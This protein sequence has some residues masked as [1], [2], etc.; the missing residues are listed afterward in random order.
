MHQGSLNI[1]CE[2]H[3]KGFQH[4]KFRFLYQ[5]THKSNDHCWNYKHQLIDKQHTHSI[6]WWK[7]WAWCNNLIEDFLFRPLKKMK[8]KK[9][10]W[11]HGERLHNN[12]L[13]HGGCQ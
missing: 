10:V 3:N 6:A 13:S 7:G 8:K 11:A 5:T 12:N 4:W 2:Q 1:D 9:E